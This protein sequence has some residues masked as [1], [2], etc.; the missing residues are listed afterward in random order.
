MLVEIAGWIGAALVLLSYALVSLG[1][2]A[3][4]TLLNQGLNIVGASG[5]AWNGV[6]HRA[7][8]IVALDAIWVLVGVIAVVGVVRAA[9]A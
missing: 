5:L 3:P 2:L 6:V 1:R 9:R 8:P 7:W 4:R